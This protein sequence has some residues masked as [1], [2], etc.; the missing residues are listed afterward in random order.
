MQRMP[1]DHQ[2][3]AAGGRSARGS[4]GWCEW[5]LCPQV[6]PL[7]QGCQAAG[8]A[9]RPV[10][11]P[12]LHTARRRPARSCSHRRCAGAESGSTHSCC[13]AGR[14]AWTCA[15]SA[16][17]QTTCGPSSS[18]TRSSAGRTWTP[19]RPC[20]TAPCCTRW[21]LRWRSARQA[22][23]ALTGPAWP[24]VLTVVRGAAACGACVAPSSQARCVQAG[25]GKAPT[26]VLAAHHLG[27]ADVTARYT[28][29]L[30]AAHSRRASAVRPAL[31]WPLLCLGC[32]ARPQQL[33][34]PC[35]WACPQ[36]PRRTCMRALL[37]TR[38]AQ[39]WASAGCGAGQQPAA[40]AVLAG[41]TAPAAASWPDV[42]GAG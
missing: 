19:A 29:D 15:T 1:G 20:L 16:T 10:S 23:G 26:Y 36:A 24:A 40:G 7:Q 41:D 12:S 32:M 39:G 14:P 42:R 33:P 13:A 25:W 22:A 30:P 11:L 5:Q 18:G 21:A 38:L 6:P 34:E 37:A 3:S 35:I 2:A 4:W 17:A 8:D 27:V 9:P 28:Q 31:R